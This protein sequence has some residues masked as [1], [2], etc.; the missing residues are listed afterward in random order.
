MSYTPPITAFVNSSG[1]FT[2]LART[3]HYVDTSGGVATVTLPAADALS[4]G[5]IIEFID[6][7]SAATNNITINRAGAD[8]IESERD[9]GAQTS[10][11][12]S[13]DN[14]VV[15]F[16][17]D[18]VS[19]WIAVGG[20][21]VGAGTGGEA[22]TASNQGA[23]A[24]IFKAKVGVDLQLRS[25]VGG[26]GIAATQNTNDVTLD[27]AL[28]VPAVKIANYTA[29]AGELVRTDS[30]GG[31]F[32]VTLPTAVGITG[33]TITVKDSNDSS[34]GANKVTI[35]GNAAETIDGNLTVT[36]EKGN[37]LTLVSDGANWLLV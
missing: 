10:F 11:V 25:I 13:A 33:Q 22:N 20:N 36:L 24:G 1:V 35:D 31:A 29:A 30:S 3:S 6:N 12:I 2:A 8:T 4:D 14:Q 9:G 21:T 17:S 15:V 27:A 23:G 32:T 16:R 28:A 34:K 26:S 18:G 5:E 7:G 19:K 37:A